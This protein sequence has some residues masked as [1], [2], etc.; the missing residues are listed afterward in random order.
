MTCESGG[1]ICRRCNR[2]I[3][4]HHRDTS[5]RLTCGIGPTPPPPK[6]GDDGV[7]V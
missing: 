6:K 7:P 3:D 1:G 2:S 4:D 5:G